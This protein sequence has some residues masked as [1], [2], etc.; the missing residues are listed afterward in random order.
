[1]TPYRVEVSGGVAVAK[2]AEE[3][4]QV[5]GL[6]FLPPVEGAIIIL[7]M[8]GANSVLEGGPVTHRNL[9]LDLLHGQGNALLIRLRR[10]IWNSTDPAGTPRTASGVCS[11]G[12]K[13][14]VDDIPLPSSRATRSTS[15]C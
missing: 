1:M 14:P 5:P 15:R 10:V 6:H 3:A 9:C 8:E 7:G 4:H 11:S 13:A 2:G 12:P